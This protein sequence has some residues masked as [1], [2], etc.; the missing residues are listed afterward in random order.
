[1]SNPEQW[2]PMMLNIAQRHAG[3]EPLLDTFFSFLQRKTDFFTGGEPGAARKVVE[4]VLDKYASEAERVALKKKEEARKKD[5]KA[6][7]QDAR[8]AQKLAEV[9]RQADEERKAKKAK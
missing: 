8:R 2:D 3:I 1:M 4:K 6:R 7:E 9:Q 5:A